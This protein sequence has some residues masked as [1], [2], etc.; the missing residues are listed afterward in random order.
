MEGRLKNISDESY[1]AKVHHRNSNKTQT[2]KLNATKKTTRV[3]RI[4]TFYLKI[5]VNK[6]NL[7]KE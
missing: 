4:H 1:I 3:T 2:S 6:K 5:F 7:G